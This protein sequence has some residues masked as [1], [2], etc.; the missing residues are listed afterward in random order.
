MDRPKLVQSQDMVYTCTEMLLIFTHMDTYGDYRGRPV[1]AD[2]P[3]I[4]LV[5]SFIRQRTNFRCQSCKE[6][7]LFRNKLPEDVPYDKLGSCDFL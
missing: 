1:N 6:I 7:N 4:C 3:Q 2:G 5:K